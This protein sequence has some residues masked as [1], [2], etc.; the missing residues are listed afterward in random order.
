MKKSLKLLPVACL[1]V[2]S[3]GCANDYANNSTKDLSKMDQKIIEV[4]TNEIGIGIK[5]F[6]VN[7]DKLQ[8]LTLALGNQYKVENSKTYMLIKNEFDR[9]EKE[10]KKNIE[11]MIL[12][13]SETKGT[14]SIDF[15][16]ASGK[17][18]HY[19]NKQEES[20][21]DKAVNIDSENES[22]KYLKEKTVETGYDLA[23]IPTMEKD[24]LSIKYVIKYNKL[25][26]VE[27]VKA[28]NMSIEAPKINTYNSLSSL[29]AEKGDVLLVTAG[30]KVFFV[31]F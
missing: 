21:L 11:S 23:L 12:E 20:Y 9:D 22:R 28:G 19:V 17:P 10:F 4:K 8:D 2:L 3:A 6:T 13:H 26:E 14:Q 1:L 18:I 31:D 15:V 29:K 7:E 24:N 25:M 16:M 27:E 30:D 5:T